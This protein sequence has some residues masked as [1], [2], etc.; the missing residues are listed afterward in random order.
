MDRASIV[1]QVLAWYWVHARDL[2]WRRPQTP[3]WGVL[4]S[5]VMLQQTPVAR[6]VEPWS[7]WMVRWPTPGALAADS[8]GDAIA[9][10]GRLGY[11]RR[12]QRLHQAATVLVERF[13]G[14][15]PASLDDLRALPGV[16][17]YT[18]AAVASFGF[19]QRQLV[20][21]TNVRRLLARVESGM[22]HP[23]TSVTASERRRAAEWVPQQPAQ[24]AAWAVASMELGA[25]VCTARAPACTQ[26]PLQASCVWLARGRP[27]EDGVRQRSQAYAGTDRQARGHLLEVL[28]RQRQGVARDVLVAS[29]AEPQQAARA[30]ASLVTDG[31]VRI[32]AD[33]LA[34][35]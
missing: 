6:V 17:D 22:A 1:S 12:A 26:C 21:D 11:P 7:R 25:L 10:W 31:L 33:G 4:V 8:Q 16:G 23:S 14:H 2:P 27:R 13:D 29:W 18:A 9:A 28:R 30:F 24:A 34:S 5:E 15:L 32:G 19:G 35:L 3:P 20:L